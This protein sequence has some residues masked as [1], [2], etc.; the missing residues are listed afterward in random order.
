[1]GNI[2]NICLSCDDNYAEHAGVVIASILANAKPED[3]PVFYI[4]DGDISDKH[5][6]E[7]LELKKI[8]DCK[9][10]FISINKDNFSEYRK[11]KSHEYITL[12]T[13][14]RLLLPT[15]LPDVS[16]VIYLDCDMI[17]LTS[18]FDLF[19][20]NMYGCPIAGVHD[21]KR[22]RVRENKTYVNA[23]ML[24]I[25]LDKTRELKLEEKF[26]EWT[27]R[28]IDT[29][30]VG[31]QEIINEVCRDNIC[32][33]DDRWNVQSS[34]FT[35]RSS[36]TRYPKI[37]H[38]TAKIK[39][40]HFGSFSYHR[41]LYFKYLQM[42]PWK[43]SRKEFRR[44]TRENQKASVIAYFKYR[45]HFFLRPKFYRAVYETYVKKE[46][47]PKNIKILIT[48]RKNGYLSNDDRLVP[49]QCG[50]K[51]AI[52]K[53]NSGKFS[54]EDYD[55]L[56]KN[57]IGDD[58]GDNISERYGTL[59]EMTAVYWA[60]KNYDK[61]GNPDYIGLNH[62][63][64]YFEINYENLDKIFEKYDLI[65]QKHDFSKY[66]LYEVWIKEGCSKSFIDNAISICKCV[67]N[68]EGR[69]IE[70]FLKGNIK[71]GMPN[72]FIMK[73]DDFFNYCNFIFPI[74]FKLPQET[75]FG[76]QAGYFAALLTSYY[77]FRLS[78]TKR[79]YNTSI[80]TYYE[81]S[82]KHFFKDNI[83]SI[84]REDLS[85]QSHLVIK[86]LGIKIKIRMKDKEDE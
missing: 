15:L 30:K 32:I 38:Y 34:N 65:K 86:I 3:E 21:I 29:I 71:R 53:Y 40:W 48:C 79:A 85:I 77:L 14:Y 42:T 23:G 9:I 22:K 82:G 59:K 12:A 11:V 81:N 33:V 45:P 54:Q 75:A 25:D 56:M 19:Y 63:R 28:H 1:M 36:Y 73:K 76:R 4:L 26:L 31:D 43:L 74:I 57:T 27:K 60:W 78:K 18:L 69:K 44:W 61:L 8:K 5:K 80:V 58:T 16:R 50:R 2:I 64:Q 47:K 13:Y 51:I 62:Y 10:N 68:T 67:N 66:S 55:W 49:I 24:V 37:I 17:V 84:K 20:R 70:K 83:F 46:Y 7:I 39:P 6:Q 35:N 52:E 72:M 41:N